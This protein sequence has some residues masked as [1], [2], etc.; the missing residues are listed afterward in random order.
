VTNPAP[1]NIS[2]SVREKLRNIAQQRSAD[3]GLILVKY[4]L[5]RILF[6]KLD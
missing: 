4:G 2:T 3:F 1:K 5:E 6:R